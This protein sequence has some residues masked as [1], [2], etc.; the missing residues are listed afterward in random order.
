[1]PLASTRST[2][3]TSSPLCICINAGGGGC[4]GV[5]GED[6]GRLV[7][8]PLGGSQSRPDDGVIGALA[9]PPVVTRICV[10]ADAN[11][12]QQWGADPS[13]DSKLGSPEL[14]LLPPIPP[15][16]TLN[17]DADVDR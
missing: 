7:V 13:H 11:V 3:P 2:P 10:N 12:A 4:H 17:S 8:D 14:L 9:A 15:A 1:M 6:G 16:S 5:Y